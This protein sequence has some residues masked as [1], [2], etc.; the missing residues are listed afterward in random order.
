[1]AGTITKGNDGV[2]KLNS[3]EEVPSLKEW[4][5]N[6]T[7]TERRTNVSVMASNSDHLLSGWDIVAIIGRGWRL[8]L[9]FHWQRTNEAAAPFFSA[10]QIGQALELTLYP[11]GTLIRGYSGTASLASISKPSV[12]AD[13]ITQ[14]VSL[15]GDGELFELE[16]GEL[17]DGMVTFAGDEFHTFADDPMQ[18]F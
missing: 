4:T 9:V 5:L 2:V 14:A 12:V 7:A 10:E 16:P 18:V 17:A 8:N 1:M 11:A 3:G 6:T 15:I 13:A